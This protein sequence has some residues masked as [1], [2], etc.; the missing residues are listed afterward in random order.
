MRTL[1]ATRFG[2]RLAGLMM[3]IATMSMAPVT[4]QV[5][6]TPALCPGGYWHYGSLCLN[7]NTGDVVLASAA[8][9]EFGC[10]PRYWRMDA[11]CL[12]LATGDVELAAPSQSARAGK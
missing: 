3:V 8:P 7:N 5:S 10:R 12:D 9:A 11:V 2:S 6:P 1:K 4:A